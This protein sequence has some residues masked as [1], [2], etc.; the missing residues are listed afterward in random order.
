MPSNIAIQLA[1]L[2]HDAVIE[3]FEVDATVLG[4]GVTR[5]HNATNALRGSVVWQGNAFEHWPIEAS[6][7][8]ASAN[9]RFARPT[10]KVSNASGVIGV[11]VREYRGLKG[12]RLTRK[13][14]LARYL[15]AVNFP[16]GVNASADPA[17]HYPDDVWFL[18]RQAQRD[19]RVVVYELASPMDV[20]GVQLPRRQVMANSC[21][22]LAMGGYRGPN[23]G[24]TGAA[25]AKADDS[26]TALLGEDRC[27]GRLSSCRLRQWPNSELGF[28]G[29]P[30][31]G[32]MRN[33]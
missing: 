9:G 23:C 12:A 11:L 28:G 33:V 20:A 17:T 1:T 22:W 31:A 27:G 7:F 32:V 24:Y 25:V 8:A 13:R 30:G 29:F 6:G 16:G 5:F 3:L 21:A 2:A 26:A 19:K 18:D 4:G 14:T 10:L 15:D